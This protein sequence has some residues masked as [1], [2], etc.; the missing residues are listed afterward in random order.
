MKIPILIVLLLLTMGLFAMPL[1]AQDVRMGEVSGE[2][3]DM[4]SKPIVGAKIDYVNIENGKT[5]H[6]VTGQDGTFHAIGIMLGVY[7]IEITGP[8]GKHIYSG[9]K[10][11]Y[12]AGVT[13]RKGEQGCGSTIT[14][15]IS[16][17]L[18]LLP[19]KASLVPFK[20]PKAAEIQ[21]AAW[22]KI[23]NSNGEG[24]TPEQ[25]AQLREENAAIAKYNALMPAALAAIDAQDWPQALKL[26][27]QLTEIAPYKWQLYHN[28]G[29]V[30]KRMGL[31]KEAVA[32]LDKARQF[33]EYD[34]EEWKDKAK[35]RPVVA[36]ILIS[37]GE[38]YLA[39]GN[40]DA[41]IERFRQAAEIDPNP[42][43]AYMH[44]CQS[45][46]NNGN[47]D[48]AIESC[49]KAIASEPARLEFYQVLASIQSNLERY[50]VAIQTYERGMRAAHLESCMVRV[51][52][53]SHS[54][55]PNHSNINSD[56]NARNF[57]SKKCWKAAQVQF[58]EGNAY[59]A[60]R[61][62]REA[63]DLFRQ[64]AVL[65]PVPS[66][67]YFN[68]CASLYNLK[69]L[70]GASAACDQAI[71]ADP[72]MAN[73]YYVKAATEYGMDAKRGKFRA[74]SGTTNALKKYL[75]LTPDGPHADEARAMLKELR[76]NN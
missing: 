40:M 24:L 46:Y 23:Q 35:M 60:L 30:Q 6:F 34:D 66:L 70:P 69:D 33:Y 14:N 45:Q 31:H 5:Y 21:G 13:C 3:L 27:Q 61:K 36:S 64:A 26:F 37:Q 73:A 11:V 62:Y 39:V 44:L 28:L 9:K 68:L 58:A 71:A 63:A 29:I 56:A 10:G 18:S 74:S 2:I 53:T 42:A 50:D 67:A 17:D 48:A 38:A 72:K 43:M 41:A 20:G 8:T 76:A 7:K 25:K 65:H 22:R 47:S 59:F 57:D 55:Q 52:R 51:D 75:E 1:V 15:V 12:A 32:S 54:S 4:E 19:T 49:Q 16:I